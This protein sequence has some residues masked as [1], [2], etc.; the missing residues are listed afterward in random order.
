MRQRATYARGCLP[1][2][3]AELVADTAVPYLPVA[4]AGERHGL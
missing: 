1:A 4:S 3:L 2:V